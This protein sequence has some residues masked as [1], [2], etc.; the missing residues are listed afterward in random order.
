VAPYIE[1]FNFDT[2]ETLAEE[3]RELGR[4]GNFLLCVIS[5]GI[6]LLN[7]ATR[8][9]DVGRAAELVR[10][11]ENNMDAGG[12][13]HGVLW[14][15]RL[16]EGRA[17][18]ALQ[19]KQYREAFGYAQETLERARNLGRPKYEARALVAGGLALMGSGR[20]RQA[21]ATLRQA[22]DVART[23]GGPSLFLHAAAAYLRVEA[24]ADIAC[25]ARR[26]ADTISAELPPNMVAEFLAADPVR[27][28]YELTN[29]TGRFPPIRP[30]Y[31]DGL[32]EREVEV[33]RLLAKGMTSREIGVHLVLSVRTVERHISN[34]YGKT[35]ANGRAQATAYA[36]AT[37]IA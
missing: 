30:E 29:Q 14:R 36:L 34:I 13:T 16:A 21:L 2:A 6:D 23:H 5:E 9:G 28:V 25:D 7:I 27:L 12:A 10:E 35:K 3:A 20:K 24:E 26:V 22:V 11:V 33:L 17:T 15:L 37:G 32:T 1:T 18:L 4:R 31:P 19:M 8:R